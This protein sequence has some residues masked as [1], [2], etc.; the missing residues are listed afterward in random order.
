MGLGKGL[1]AGVLDDRLLGSGT[2]G[3]C[4]ALQR[5]RHRL[6]RGLRQQA[7]AGGLQAIGLQ[8]ALDDGERS[9]P[10]V[11]MNSR[12]AWG[13]APVDRCGR[14]AQ[15]WGTAGS[16]TSPPSLMRGASPKER[17]GAHAAGRHVEIAR[18]E[19]A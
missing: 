11:L 14:G 17:V 5:L 1:A 2:A 10:T 12:P 13:M 19:E 15:P 3:R 9:P 4:S 7:N 16:P 8:P 6:R 18:L